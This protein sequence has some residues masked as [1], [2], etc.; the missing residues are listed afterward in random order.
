MIVINKN[1]ND[2]D[3]DD[4][5]DSDNDDNN[6][7]VNGNT[8]IIVIFSLNKLGIDRLSMTNIWLVF[9]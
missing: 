1:N 8:M 6:D 5:N 9:F 3:N 7:T 2:D 4:D